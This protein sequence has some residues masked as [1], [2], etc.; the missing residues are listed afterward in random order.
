MKTINQS[1]VF[2]I[3]V[4]FLLFCFFQGV[5]AQQDAVSGATVKS[6]VKDSIATK[7]KKK[8]YKIID[9][10]KIYEVADVMPAFPDGGQKGLMRYLS[11]NVT[12]PKDAMKDKVNGRVVLRFIVRKDGS[13]SDIKIVRP[14]YPSCDDEALRVISQ[15]PDWEPGTENGEPV[16][17]FFS[18]PIRF[19]MN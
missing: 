18:L 9:G 4:F 15:M 3:L 12:F 13:I 8:T 1:R 10:E 19:S 5:S 17:V 7:S 6:N 2:S 16:N 14:L 11:E